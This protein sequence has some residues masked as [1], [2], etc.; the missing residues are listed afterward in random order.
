MRSYEDDFEGNT[1]HINLGNPEFAANDIKPENVA[2]SGSDETIS[3][4][5]IAVNVSN[6]K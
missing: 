6:L 2:P 1:Y 4:A 3:H 5:G